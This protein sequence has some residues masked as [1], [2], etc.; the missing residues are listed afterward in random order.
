MPLHVHTVTVVYGRPRKLGDSEFYDTSSVELHSHV[1]RAGVRGTTTANLSDAPRRRPK[2]M[3]S[4]QLHSGTLTMYLT[5]KKRPIARPRLTRT[6]VRRT[7]RR[8]FGVLPC[9]TRRTA[10]PSVPPALQLQDTGRAVSAIWCILPASSRSRSARKSPCTD[11]V[12]SSL[13][14][15]RSYASAQGRPHA[16]ASQCDDIT[17]QACAPACTA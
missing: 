3:H 10:Q 12:A 1:L 15:L 2:N 9:P 4:A 13:T 14:A 17:A 6:R 7:S 8:G 16:A 11:F 5:K